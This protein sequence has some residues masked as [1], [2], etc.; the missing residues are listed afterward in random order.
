[1]FR[2]VSAKGRV[3]KNIEMNVKSGRSI[4]FMP[5]DASLL[6][7]S[8]GARSTTPFASVSSLMA[9]FTTTK[10]PILMPS[11]KAGSSVP[12]SCRTNLTN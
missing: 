5:R 11:M 8:M 7:E 2:A 9:E 1:M 10:P 3:G 4:R 12:I 6:S